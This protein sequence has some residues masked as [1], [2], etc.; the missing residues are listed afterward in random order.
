LQRSSVKIIAFIEWFAF[1]IVMQMLFV[2]FFP[3]VR[4]E[5]L[6]RLPAEQLKSLFTGAI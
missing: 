3:R 1:E 4:F 2:A 5:K 6:C